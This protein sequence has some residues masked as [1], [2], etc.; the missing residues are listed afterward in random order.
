ME[1]QGSLAKVL[2]PSVSSLEP[3]T[4]YMTQ[5]H[6]AQSWIFGGEAKLSSE[7]YTGKKSVLW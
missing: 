5:P 6:M 7:M 4:P 3:W 1:G 2:L